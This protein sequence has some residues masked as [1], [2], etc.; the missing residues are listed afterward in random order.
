MK[1]GFWTVLAVGVGVAWCAGPLVAHHVAQAPADTV[2]AR[3]ARVE[4]ELPNTMIMIKGQRKPGTTLAERMAFHK[5]PGVSIAVINNG[6]IEWAR[7]YGVVQVG[8]PEPV[9]TR[10]LFQAASI[11]K[12]VAAFL[13]MRLVERG[14][15]ALDQDVNTKLTSW[16]VPENELTAVQKVTLGRLLSHTAG[17]TMHGVPSSASGTPMPSVVQI[18]DGTPPADNPPVRVTAVPGSIFRYSGGGYTIMQQLLVDVTKTPFQDLAA[19]LVFTPIGMTDSTFELRPV[20]S[21]TGGVANGHAPD[22]RVLDG[23]NRASSALAAAGLWTTAT[24]LAKFAMEIQ[25]AAK[26]RSTV[27]TEA[28][29]RALV[30]P[31]KSDYSMGLAMR[32]TGRAARFAHGGSNAGFKA[33]FM[34]YLE[35]GQGAAVMTNADGGEML[36]AEVLRS[37]AREYGWPELAPTEKSV[38]E[39]D[40]AILRRY[41]GRY[42][43]APDLVASVTLEGTRLVF[44][45]GTR[46]AVDLYAEST[47]RFFAMSPATT[48]QFIS[49][50][51]GTVTHAVVNGGRPARR[52]PQ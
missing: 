49:A 25:R 30:T 41:E 51:D 36:A 28:T 33:Q 37:I 21:H 45:M 3:I 27:I 4:A 42:E 16:K 12:P 10:T 35:T 20:V 19:S 29:A 18:L 44:R 40:A 47:S 2:A 43:V 22:G 52:L 31:I 14:D 1:L 5:T 13:A 34:A 7:S 50:Q 23:G 46:P 38:I 26:G 24:D 17:T 11:S 9:T 15:V 39:V 6:E 48:I 8:A 32:G